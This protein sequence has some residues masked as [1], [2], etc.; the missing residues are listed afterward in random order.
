MRAFHKQAMMK[1][2]IYDNIPVS[3]I[4]VDYSPVLCF[5]TCPVN[6]DEAKALTNRN[7][8]EFFNQNQQKR[9]R[10][11]SIKHLRI[12]ITDCPVG[13]SYWAAKN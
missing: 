13:V 4:G 3:R 12:T 6:M 2:K 9:C 8:T 11:G 5:E 1:Q 10:C 7:Q